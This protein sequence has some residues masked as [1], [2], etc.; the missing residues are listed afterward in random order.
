MDRITAAVVLL[1]TVER[2]SAS[3]AAEELRMSRAMASRYIASIEE[4]SG[5]RLLHRTTRRLSLTSAGER[6]LELCREMVRVADAVTE[7]AVH[8]D[9][10][11]GLLRVTAPSI[12][13]EAQLIPHFSEFAT[14][15]PRIKIDLQISDRSVDL[16]QDRI[17]IAIRIA[18]HLD[19][20]LTAKR[21]GHCPSRL[22]ASKDYL[23]ACGEP[24]SPENL[25]AH[26]CLTYAHLGGSE[27]VLNKDEGEVT[28][29]VSGGFQTNDALA[30][31]RAAL[32]GLGIAMLPCFAADEEV[33]AG[34]LA[35]V[36]PD[37]KP[38]SLGIHAL[39]VSRKH[40]PTAARALIDFLSEKLGSSPRLGSAITS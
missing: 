33:R 11:H 20:S 37:W 7:V 40:L 12:L 17:D 29:A 32:S 2:G 1:K 22:Y 15:Y 30:L 3:A 6:V 10:P 31:Q 18:N 8:S 23:A 25:I 28:V 36:L 13:A 16:V 5:T 19:P 4:W 9:T 21:L 35:V 38:R 34:K 39:Y 26:R 24:A 14:K 27:W